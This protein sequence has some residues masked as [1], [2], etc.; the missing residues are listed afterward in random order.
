MAV[1][2][3][4][5]DAQGGVDHIDSHRTVLLVAGPYA[6][7]G[8]IVRQNSSFPGLLKTVFRILGLPPLNLFDATATDLSDAFTNEPDFTPYKLLATDPA[9]FDPT[10]AKDPLESAPPPMSE[11]MDDPRVLKEQHRKR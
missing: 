5:D 9:I 10:K 11:R 4:E 1:L 3:T 8:H 6:R 2:V 7:R